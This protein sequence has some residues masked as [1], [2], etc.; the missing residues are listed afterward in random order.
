MAQPF[1]SC[2]HGW[3][4]EH[5][6]MEL[7][8]KLQGTAGEFVYGQ[9]SRTIREN[10]STLVRELEFR[11]RKIENTRTFG[12]KFSNRLQKPG[13]SAEDYASD[14]KS[15][16]DGAYP[17]RDGLTR[18]EDL[19]R[20]FLDSLMDERTRVQVEFVKEPADIDRVVYEVVNFLEKKKAQSQSGQ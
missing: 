17:N 4:D 14:L 2:I 10:Y 12:S 5:K 6:L 8:P 15:L 13:E 11:F 16:Y 20:K 7:L 19:L 9:L 1:L 3:T 18:Q